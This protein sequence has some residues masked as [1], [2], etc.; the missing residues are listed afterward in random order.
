MERILLSEYERTFKR[1]KTTIGIGLYFVLIALECFFLY[2]TGGISFYDADHSVQLN[3][4]NTAPFFLRE[5]G[6]F[7]NFIL[8][9]MFVID[10]FNGEEHSGAFRLVL[11]R[12]QKRVKLFL[13]KWIVQASIF[14]GITLLTWFIATIFGQMMMPHVS[15]TTFLNTESMHLFEGLFYT[16]KFYSVTYLIFLGVIGIASFMSLVMPNPILAYMG[17]IACLIG[18][19]YVSDQF[20]YFISVSDAIFSAFGKMG[21]SEFYMSLLVLFVISHMMNISVWHRKQWKG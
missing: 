12:P 2:L 1:K 14:L 4:I 15:E 13:A 9:P 6:L 8:I 19:I 11:I 16:I 17:T 7:I 10:S 21:H 20:I 3:S 5:L 18:G